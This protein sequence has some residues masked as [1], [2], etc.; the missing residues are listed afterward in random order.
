MSR[1]ERLLAL[2]EILRVHRRPVSGQQLAADLGISLRTLYRDIASLQA[3]GARIDGA[4]GLG[5]LLRPGF[6]LPPL[7]FLP[8][9]VEALALGSRWVIAHGDLRLAQAAR[10]ALARVSAVLPLEARLDLETSGLLI[11][12][13]GPVAGTAGGD[14]ETEE[15][16][17]PGDAG[18][19][20]IRL[21][22]RR[23]RKLHIEYRDA[24]GRVTQRTIWPFALGYFRRTRVVAAW[25]ELRVALRHF[26]TD[27]IQSL[28]L[29]EERY[30]Q[31]RPV[32][33][34]QWRREQGI[35][36]DGF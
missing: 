14:G 22:I 35:A 36:A 8:E 30:P 29:D 32:L 20:T 23:E 17:S 5:Y 11:G 15:A 12:P 3:R 26:R 10:S 18:I 33:L 9:E 27:Q 21:A 31:R 34:A 1:A 2:V 6:T 25:C 16:A 24:S 13:D 28:A 4:P 7:M 19:A